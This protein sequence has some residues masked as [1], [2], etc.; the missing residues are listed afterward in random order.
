MSVDPCR[1]AETLLQ[2]YLDRRLTPTE[3]SSIERHLEECSYCNDRYVF[4]RRLREQVK[5]CCC[6]DPA[7]AGLVERVR[8]RC[9]DQ[10]G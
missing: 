2:P 4:E 7:P 3:V 8:L 6:G 10:S 5:D 9:H 1:G